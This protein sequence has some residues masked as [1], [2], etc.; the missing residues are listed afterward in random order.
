[1]AKFIAKVGHQ[2]FL[3]PSEEAAI[4][5]L[6]L[7]GTAQ[8]IDNHYLGAGYGEVWSVDTAKVSVEVEPDFTV[9]TRAEYQALRDEADAKTRANQES[10]A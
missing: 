5:L 4:S 3:M 1:M 8:A 9:M 7:L 6:K 10:A 2:A